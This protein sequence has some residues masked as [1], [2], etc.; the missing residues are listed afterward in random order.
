MAGVDQPLEPVGAAVGV[1]GRVQVDAVVAPAAPRRGTRRPASARRA[2]TPR[3]TRWSRRSMAA[4]KVP[5]GRERADV[6]L[7]EHRA[8]QRR[9][10]AS[11]ASVHANAAWSTTADGPSTPSG[12][13]RRARVGTRRAA[14]EREARSA[15]PA[16]ASSTVAPPPAAARRASI[17]TRRVADDHLDASRR[18]APTPRNSCIS[19]PRASSGHR[20]RAPAARP[21]GRRPPSHVARR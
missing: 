5:S 9:R 13:A 6:Q 3:S 12:C 8:A 18:A 17:G 20:E 11:R 2:S 1:V 7:V 14:V 19:A 21:A 15:S 10:P 4:S 16:P